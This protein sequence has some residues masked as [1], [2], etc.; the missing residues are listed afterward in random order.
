M[1]S[2]GAKDH[3][4][5]I[6]AARVLDQCRKR[7]QMITEYLGDK[8]NPSVLD[9]DRTLLSVE[10]LLHYHLFTLLEKEGGIA[11]DL[12]TSSSSSSFLFV[13]NSGSCDEDDQMPIAYSLCGEDEQ[14]KVVEIV[15]YI[16]EA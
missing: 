6:D 8:V 4:Y 15:Q 1:R 5:A 3:H 14:S 10:Q 9:M 12:D 7:L 11:Q 16:L 2:S 13:S